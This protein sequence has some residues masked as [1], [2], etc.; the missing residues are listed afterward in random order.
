M[1]KMVLTGPLAGKTV[2]LGHHQFINGE[3]VLP[4]DARAQ[5]GAIRYLGR[6]YQAFPAGSAELKATQKDKDDGIQ[7][8]A[9]QAAGQGHAARVSGGADGSSGS[10]SAPGA[11]QRGADDSDG[12]AAGSSVVVPGGSGHEDSGLLSGTVEAIKKAVLSLDPADDT[13]WTDEGLPSI[14]AIS[15]I[16]GKHDIARKDIDAA[17]E[18]FNREDAEDAASLANL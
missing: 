3:M 4:G 11:V 13:V 18:G 6:C 10:V 5:E 8:N 15:K 9:S 12:S 2:R 16:V 14:E 7:R 1:T 17:T